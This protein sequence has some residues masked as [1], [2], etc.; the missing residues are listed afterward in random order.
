MF[1]SLKMLLHT[2][3]L[4]PAG[5]LLLAAAGAWVIA[6]ARRP[7]ARRSG[8]ALLVAGLALLWLL[9]TPV[10]A[11]A[12][13]RAAQRYGALDLNRPLHSQAIVILA[14]SY[15]RA[16]APEYDGA[17]AVGGRLLGRVA[18]G[19][20]VAQRTGL[21]VLVSGTRRE[22]LAMQASLARN[23][24]IATR[25]VEGG[26]RDTFEN[27]RFSARMLRAAGVSRII[28]VTDAEHEWR[29]AHEFA[30]AGLDVLP[31]PER[32]WAQDERT[33]LSYLP[34]AVALEDSTDALYELLGD[35][36]RRALAAFG[37]RRQ[38]P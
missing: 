1:V 27:A 21:P 14:G 16:S 38:T 33:F 11:D 25:W 19:A 36:V 29:A 26:S 35:L 31:A 6:R 30:S 8:W 9:A 23:F 20:F 10:I 32:I 13:S 34:S 4:P 15:S 18:Y 3:L 22:T 7:G 37:L 24:H 5:P 2:L 12:L 28:L 17:P